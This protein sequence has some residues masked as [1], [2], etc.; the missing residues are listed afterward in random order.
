MTSINNLFLHSFDFLKLIMRLASFLIIFL[1]FNILSSPSISYGFNPEYSDSLTNAL[2][3]TEDFKKKSETLIK[4]SDYFQ[5]NNPEKALEYSYQALEIAKI[6]KY[7]AGILRANIRIAKIYRIMT[8]LN[9]SLDFALKANDLAKFMEMKNELAESYHILGNIYLDLG[10]YEISSEYL[11]KCL[12]L[13]EDKGNKKGIEQILTS[14][15]YLY[16]EQNKY[17]KALD[18]FLKSLAIAREINDSSGISKGLNNIAAIYGSI[19]EYEKIGPYLFEALKISKASGHKISEGI[20]YVNIG[21]IYKEMN[22]HDSI[23]YYFKKAEEIFSELNNIP[24]LATV[25]YNLSEYYL[26]N[27]SLNNSLEYAHKA[28]DLG[29]SHNLKK[30]IYDAADKLHKIYLSNNDLEN[31]SKFQIIK[32]Q[33][34]DSMNLEQSLTNL[35]RLE[36]Q[37]DFEKQNHEKLH[38]QQKK[39]FIII[40]IIIILISI[41]VTFFLIMVNRRVKTKNVQLKNQRLEDEVEYKNKELALSVMT[42]LRKNEILSEIS[43]KLISISKKT[44]Q[45]ETKNDIKEIAGDLRKNSD[46]EIWEEFELRFKQVHGDFYEK[47][48]INYPNLTPNEKKICAFLRLN[49]SSK[50]ISNLTGQS[51]STIEVARYRLRKKLEISNKEINLITFLSQI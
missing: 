32:Y 51:I 23:Y 6:N 3:N 44:S 13:V 7:S 33:V 36:L 15:G 9:L 26:E 31:A 27:D 1:I 35:S 5:N 46:N 37:Y 22:K 20:N 28:F 39:D 2:K 18:Y 45:T 8:N 19:N 16:F 49:M 17:E 42:L 43:N 4:L 30:V 41:I 24:L 10:E 12:K 47:L 21:V 48:E 14:I 38:K 50:D 34:K 25:Y 40:I 11:F 29:R